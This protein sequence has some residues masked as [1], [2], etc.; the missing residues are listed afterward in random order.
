MQIHWQTLKQ[1]EHGGYPPTL[2][3]VVTSPVNLSFTQPPAPLPVAKN[4]S[5]KTRFLHWL[6]MLVYLNIFF[7]LN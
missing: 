7:V 1:Q 4:T 2:A 6:L 5:L 3:T